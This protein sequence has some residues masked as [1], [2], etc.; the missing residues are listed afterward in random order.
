MKK[1]FLAVLAV[2]LF[3]QVGAK[4]GMWL[5]TL[6]Q[7]YNIEEM[8]EMGFRLSAEDVY[9][10]NQNSLKDAVV[11]FGKGCTGEIIS[12][13]GLLLTNHHCALSYIQSHSE[14]ANDYL[15]NGFWAMS[16]QEELPNP[17]LTAK[18]LERMEDVTDSVF[19]G[20]DSL[21]AGAL[22]Q[23]IKENIA[24][25]ELFAS[26]SDKYETEVKP[27][28]YG[29]QYF[30]HVYKV[31]RDVRLVGAP[32]SSIGKFGG[33]TDNWMWP[34]HTGDFS[35]FRVYADE[36]NEPADY[37][38]T[39]VPYQ[40][41]K[42]FPI[43]LNGIKADDFVM[44]MGFPGST[45]QYLPS[46]EVEM[47][48]QQV[49]PGNIKI[50]TAKLDVLAK[51]MKKDPKV[52]IQY[53]SKYYRTSN[54]WKKWKGEIVGLKRMDAV[55]QKQAFEYDFQEWYAWNDSLDTRYGNVLPRFE[56]L[57][58][59]LLPYEKA[60]NYYQEI[61]MKGVEI[62]QL[63]EHLPVNDIAWNRAGE[64]R[65]ELYKKALAIKAEEFYK[66]FDLE[67]D[68]ELFTV[69]L[70]MLKEDLDPSFLPADFVE[71]FDKLDDEKLVKKVYNKSYLADENKF[72]EVIRDFD[73]K[74]I[75]RLQKDPLVKLYTSLNAHYK[76][77]VEF[78]YNE[79]REEIDA[80]QKV[81]M[82]GI[83]LM[84]KDNALFPDANFTLRVAY[85]KAEGYQ[86]R[87]G[88]SYNY[89]TTLGGVMEKYETG[90]LDY[91]IPEKL[92]ELYQAADYGIYGQ[93]GQMPVAFTG[94]V[95][96]TGGNSGSPAINAQGQ[97]VGINF[98]RCW[99]GTMSDIFYDPQ[100][101][102]NI[103]MDIRYMLFIVD[104]FAGAGYL[105]DEM[106]LVE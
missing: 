73:G 54:A 4:E 67:T 21:Q 97:L 14:V 82:D 23:K 89:F 18:F 101:C 41:K 84:Q 8:R 49:N 45:R 95:H 46:Q 71:M 56:E 78:V 11:I 87:D 6:L 52:N 60:Y 80:V 22:Q 55:K 26:D 51:H 81:Y 17:G 10:V 61:L 20:T 38:E 19:A 24:R 91:I 69:L 15:S 98:D 36:N 37:A 16:Q 1:V 83:M 104:H 28:F 47:I 100:V 2:V 90:T 32:P 40:P 70:R 42:F 85:G 59:H 48:M 102:R 103:M 3:L 93:D 30:L 105:L 64:R 75:S 68:E 106:E 35:I 34:R 62:F 12:N 7:K 72:R 27:L 5:P 66:D 44:L 53:A 9:S 57:Y 43:S 33:D 74:W 39:N 77:N 13:Q 94:S 29:N 31:Y 50:R 96:T 99:E 88:V 76:K 79:L 92:K 86:P 63:A 25:I 58:V 65:R